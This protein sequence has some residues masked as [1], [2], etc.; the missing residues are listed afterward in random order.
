L[1]KADLLGHW[2]LTDGRGQSCDLFI[3]REVTASPACHAIHPALAGVK[4]AAIDGS[5]LRLVDR[6]KQVLLPFDI[7]DLDSP[8]GVG[9]A[10]ALRLTRLK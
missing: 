4:A 10:E 3:R 9:G 2:R 5:T 7:S 1:L 6:K 8:K